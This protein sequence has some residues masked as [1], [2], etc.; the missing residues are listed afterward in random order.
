[1]KKMLALSMAAVMALSS[2][3]VFA[4]EETIGEVTDFNW[5]ET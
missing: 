2:C 3:A 1:M 4:G 5:A